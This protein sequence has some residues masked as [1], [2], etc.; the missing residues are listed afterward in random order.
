L[1]DRC[2]IVEKPF[3]RFGCL[4]SIG[5]VVRGERQLLYGQLYQLRQVGRLGQK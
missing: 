2:E 1:C 5:D 4:H 3:D